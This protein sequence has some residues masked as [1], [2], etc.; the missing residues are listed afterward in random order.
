[1]ILL[2]VNTIKD[3]GKGKQESEFIHKIREGYKVNTIC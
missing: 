1:M 3:I 2:K